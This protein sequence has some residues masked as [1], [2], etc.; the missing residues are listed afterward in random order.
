[1]FFPLD[2]LDKK[3]EDGLFYLSESEH[4]LIK[5]ALNFYLKEKQ[6][7]NNQEWNDI[8]NLYGDLK[9]SD[10]SKEIDKEWL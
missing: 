5:K 4:M 1:M 9:T 2:E 7:K 8:L 3:F 6:Y 10:A